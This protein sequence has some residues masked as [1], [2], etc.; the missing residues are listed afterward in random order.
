MTLK[1]IIKRSADEVL[2]N[3]IKDI[4][5]ENH[6]HFSKD[7][8]IENIPK[9][10]V[11]VLSIDKIYHIA[12]NSHWGIKI[13][14]YQ[15]SI[16]NGAHWEVVEKEAIKRFL[17]NAV[18]ALKYD[19][20][21][22]RHHLFIE[23]LWKQ[24]MELSFYIPQHRNPNLTLVNFNNGTLEINEMGEYN[25]R[26]FDKRDN[27]Y[28]QLDFDFDPNA[29]TELFD[30]YLQ[31][32]LVDPNDQLVLAEYC[33]YIFIKNYILKL[34]KVLILLGNGSNGKSIFFEILYAIIGKENISTFILSS[35]TNENG[36]YRAQLQHKLLNYSSEIGVRLD[37]TMFKILSSGEPCQARSPYGK[38]F[39]LENY[40]RFIFNCNELPIS[41]E[42]N[43][44]FFRRFIIL[45]FDQT[46]SDDEKDVQLSSKIIASEL[47][48]IFLWILN[49][50]RRLITNKKF[51]YSLKSEK[52]LNEYREQSDPVQLMLNELGYVPGYEH[53]IPLKASYEYFKN[54]CHESGFKLISIIKYSNLLKRLGYT[55]E[56]KSQGNFLYYSKVSE[57]AT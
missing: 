14:D 7:D 5:G 3:F 20:V 51:T 57:N 38:P 42:N 37:S 21:K 36:Y 54:Y 47:P 25:F 55:L 53:K 11:V 22:A 17:A 46:I 45:Y 27:L 35:L 8:Q 43:T 56:R 6:L 26:E 33:G 39:T 32:V 1:T 4:Q 19:L 41:L 2:N 15:V 50:L 52:I 40:C 44:A 9:L 18:K 16:F 31:R 24:F 10:E 34:E 12:Q 28:Y 13:V 23:D 48:G 29:R 49:G 30:K